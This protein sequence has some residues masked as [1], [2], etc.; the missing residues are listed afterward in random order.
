MPKFLLNGGYGM[1]KKFMISIIIV[2]AAVVGILFSI[3]L[4]VLLFLNPAS[5]SKEICRQHGIPYRAVIAHRGASF[6][7]PEETV[8]AYLLACDL[9]ADYLEADIQRTKDGVLVA[10][11][12]DT[13]ER[14]TNVAAVFP[15]RE[16]NNVETFT[17]AE[18]QKLDAG[19][20][21]NAKFPHKARKSFAGVKIISLE[22]LLRI[23]K[24]GEHKPGIYLEIKSPKRFPGIAQQL[25]ELLTRFGWIGADTP[26]QTQHTNI[27]SIGLSSG[28]VILQSFDPE[29]VADFARFAPTVPRLYLYD[30]DDIEKAGWN[31]ILNTAITLKAGMG[32]SG[33]VAL[34]FKNR[35]AHQASLF[36]HVYTINKSWQARLLSFFGADGFFTDRPDMLL[37]FYRRRPSGAID[38]ILQKHG[39]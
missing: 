6:Y 33:Y 11:H 8:P 36:V 24:S 28:R 16:K 21:F 15:G 35:D 26:S 14:T 23:A 31:A 22:E 29:C 25:I 4:S 1:A 18:L 12:D 13:L 38:A 9:G 32:P 3:L 39:Y 34:P 7:A 19:S 27:V 37:S 5:K 20:W 17:F 10:L 2:I 30:G